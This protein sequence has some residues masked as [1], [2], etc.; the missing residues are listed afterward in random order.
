VRRRRAAGR[1]VPPTVQGPCTVLLAMLPALVLHLRFVDAGRLIA[2][3]EDRRVH[4]AA[5]GTDGQGRGLSPNSVTTVS[6]A[7]AERRAEIGRVEDPTSARPMPRD[8]SRRAAPV[9]SGR[10]GP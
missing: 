6:G 5:V 1:D 8:R 2:G 3:P 10:G 4:R 7:A 9:R